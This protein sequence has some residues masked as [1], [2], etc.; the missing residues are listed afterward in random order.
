MIKS[1]EVYLKF[2]KKIKVGLLAIKDNKIYFEYDKEFLK[3]NLEIS[4]YKLPLKSGLMRCDDDTFEGIWGVFADS[5]PDGWGRL[6]LDRHFIKKGINP[7]SLSPLDR[8]VYVGDDGIGALV[9]EPKI[10]VNNTI[11]HLD[12]DEIFTHSQKVLKGD[13]SLIDELLT[14]N[15]SSGGARPKVLVQISDDKKEILYD[16]KLKKGFS[17]WIVK[18]A[19]SND[20]PDIG[21]IEYVYSLMV[22]EAKIDMSETY[23][24]NNK[25]FATK[26][27]DISNNKRKHLHS[28][29]GLIHSDFRY[30]TLDYD[31]IMALTLHLTKDIQEVKKVYRLAVFN[32]LT[33]NRDDHAKNFSFI[34]DNT[35]KWQFAPAYDLTYSFGVG[36]EHSTMYM[37]EGKNPTF[38]HLEKL[39]KKHNIKEYKQIINEVR[40][41]VSKFKEF[42]KSA[43][44][45]KKTISKLEKIF[46]DLDKNI[47]F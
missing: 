44:I 14:L 5:M 27:F 34:M 22:K 6:L 35:G 16:K 33:H 4:P 38:L 25:Y 7:K 39:S 46:K 42:A 36:S 37:C 21:K 20:I 30:P 23:L 11:K 13:E 32:L 8:L 2:D 43:D 45:S 9:Y 18:F 24:F 26:R 28:L 19:S 47:K 17:P 29:A 1:L 31:D 3:S 10:E 15:G 40:Y 41:G 12:L